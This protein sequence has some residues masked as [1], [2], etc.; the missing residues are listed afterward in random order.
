MQ[1]M[2]ISSLSPSALHS[3]MILAPF[4]NKINISLRFPVVSLSSCISLKNLF[5]RL[6]YCICFQTTAIRWNLFF[7]SSLFSTR[8][9]LNNNLCKFAVLYVEVLWKSALKDSGKGR[10]CD[11]KDF[12][13]FFSFKMN[14]ISCC[15]QLP[16]TPS[17]RSER[18]FNVGA[19]KSRTFRIEFW[20]KITHK[21]KSPI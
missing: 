17:F 11:I 13:W 20:K 1:I 4:V 16:K 6:I 7:A 5:S 19:I 18:L 2:I 21:R 10:R 15:M 12:I 14:W 8:T 9:I 3:R